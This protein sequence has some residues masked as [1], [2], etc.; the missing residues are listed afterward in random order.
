MIKAV[1]QLNPA[2]GSLKMIGLPRTPA[3]APAASADGAPAGGGSHFSFHDFLSILNP[4]QHLPVVGTLYRAIT[5]DTIHTPEKIAGDALYGGLW[6]AVASIADAAFE[7]ITGK[8]V[9]DTVLALFTGHHDKPAAVADNAP[10]TPDLAVPAV[11]PDANLA[12]LSAALSQKG[13]TG[14]IAQRAMLAYQ[15]SMAL[16][17][18]VLAAAQ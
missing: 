13:V 14:E 11:P 15:K 5:G 6:G 2:L 4:L 10:A 12:A 18:T 9:G 3:A 16:P 1:T 7:S 17:N 8:D